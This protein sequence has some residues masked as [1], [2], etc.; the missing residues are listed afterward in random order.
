MKRGLVFLLLI[1][2]SYPS[3][4]GNKKT[5]SKS[6]LIGDNLDI[7]AKSFVFYNEKGQVKFKDNVLI[8][9]EKLTMKCEL[10]LGFFN[11]EK[12][13]QKLDCS[14]KVKVLQKG[15]QIFCDRAIYHLEEE[16]IFFKGKTRVLQ[17]EGELI[18]EKAILLV[19]ED[20]LKMEKV[21]M[22]LNKKG[23]SSVLKD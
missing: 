9:S 20:E 16:K 22:K 14:G 18:G 21:K 7:K 12:K 2:L 6:Q 13:I 23:I 4:S 1:F 11:K 19:E 10:L 5:S 3:V 17:K 15:R 8:K